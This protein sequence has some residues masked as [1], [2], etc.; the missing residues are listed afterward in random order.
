ML[1]YLV[2]AIVVA[3]PVESRTGPI[4][5]SDIRHCPILILLMMKMT[6]IHLIENHLRYVVLI[7]IQFRLQ[8]IL[9]DAPTIG[10]GR[11]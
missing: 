2:L 3:I 8:T 6:M 1:L 9:R 11:T 5:I 7:T 4:H 10:S